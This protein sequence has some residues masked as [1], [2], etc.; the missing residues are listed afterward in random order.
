MFLQIKGTKEVGQKEVI[1]VERVERAG[2]MSQRVGVETTV[3]PNL[4]RNNTPTAHH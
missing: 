1:T 4:R 2:I 3:E